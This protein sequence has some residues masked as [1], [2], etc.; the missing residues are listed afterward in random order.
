MNKY[1]INSLIKELKIFKLDSYVYFDFCECVPSCINSYRG[2]YTEPALGWRPTGYSRITILNEYPK[3]DKLPSG[4]PDAIKRS[5]IG[6]I[7]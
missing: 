1:T 7:L 6:I 2:I 3:Y 4:N 5:K